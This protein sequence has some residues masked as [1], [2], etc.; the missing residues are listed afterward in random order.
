MNNYYTCLEW[1]SLFFG[2]KI[3]SIRPHEIKTRELSDLIRNLGKEG[4]RL[5]YCFVNPEDEVSI[6][7]VTNAG[8]LLADEKVT[9]F[10]KDFKENDSYASTQ[11]KPYN[12]AYTSENLRLL[13]L[14][15]GIYSRFKTD[16]NFHNKE[17]ENLY[18]EWIEKSVKKN[19]ADEILVYYDGN[20]EKG[21]ITLIVKN[22][23]GSIGLLAVDEKERGK[24]IG[25][26]LI[27]AAFAYFVDK[28]LHE[29]EVVTQKS[30]K[31]ACAFYESVGFKVK[32]ITN[33]YHLWIK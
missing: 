18:S 1:D 30:N 14:Q 2:Y 22:E 15:S 19:A 10:I 20:D 12:L 4:F 28:N 7:S 24:S 33:V 29:V 3:A 27:N 23:T 13:A 25:K 21:F 8:G 11:I 17:Y 31:S 9:Y 5:A 6:N 32:N 16:P 26:K